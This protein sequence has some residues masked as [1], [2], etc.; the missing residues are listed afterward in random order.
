[1]P[2]KKKGGKKKKGKA[3]EI[4][5]ETTDPLYDTM[6]KRTLEQVV[7]MLRQQLAKARLERN[8]VQLERDTTQTF[9]DITKSEV[10]EVELAALAKEREMELLDDNHRTEV[11]VYVQKVRHLEYE[12]TQ[13]AKRVRQTGEEHVVDEDADHEGRDAGL[14]RQKR[15]LRAGLRERQAANEAE[16][17]ALRAASAKSLSK[18]REQFGSSLAVLERRSEAQ[19]GELRGDLL[20]QRKVSVH[21]IEERKNLHIRSLMNNHAEAFAQVQDYYNDI[22]RDNLR[23]IGELKEE[24]VDKRHKAAANRRLMLDISAENKRLSE[25]LQS[26]LDDVAKLRHELR[27]AAK[28]RL[29]LTNARARLRAQRTQAGALAGETASLEGQHRVLE[30]ERNALHDSFEHTVRSVRRRADFANLAL[31]RRLEATEGGLEEKGHQLMQVLQ[32]ANLDPAELGA[33]TERL[34]EM[35]RVRNELIRSLSFDCARVRKQFFDALRTLRAKLAGFDVPEGEIEALEAQ[36][37]ANVGADEDGEGGVEP[38][39]RGPAGL[40]A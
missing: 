4:P 17:T 36:F 32:A 21:E 7:M 14:R 35:L 6:D 15:G 5:E 38:L 40:V 30:K 26:A 3:E 1:M 9:F 2:K 37:R 31:E 13:N 18:L 11:R 28:D 27:D 25:P 39:G 19:V 8:Y 22:T 33:V 23:L 20:L 12:H 10:G 34:D 29:G 24:V 16:V